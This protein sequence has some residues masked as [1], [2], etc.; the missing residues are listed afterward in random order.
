MSEA[1]FGLDLSSSS[2]DEEDV[3]ARVPAS[4]AA[5]S[6]PLAAGK[7]ALRRQISR[8]AD[9]VILLQG[10]WG[11]LKKR[12]RGGSGLAREISDS[13]RIEEDLRELLRLRESIEDMI[14]QISDQVTPSE[15]HLAIDLNGESERI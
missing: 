1:R 15:S 7:S 6:D 5:S 10:E 2:S 11:I 13:V 4:A 14:A 9:G 12:V 8:A 3:G